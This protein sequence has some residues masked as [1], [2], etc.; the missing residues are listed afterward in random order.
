LVDFCNAKAYKV[1]RLEANNR[2]AKKSLDEW[3]APPLIVS[4]EERLA[5]LETQ[6]EAVSEAGAIALQ[7]ALLGV[8]HLKIELKSIFDAT[9]AR[10]RELEIVLKAQAEKESSVL[11]QLSAKL[12]WLLFI[13]V[14]NALWGLGLVLI[15]L[16]SQK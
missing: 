4:S 12:D 15:W 3:T 16:A 10:K 7:E 9:A 11:S 5:G 13:V 14:M 2:M 1:P 6:L 8:E